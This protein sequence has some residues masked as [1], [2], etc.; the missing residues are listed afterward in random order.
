MATAKDFFKF[1]RERARAG[2]VIQLQSTADGKYVVYGLGRELRPLG[3]PMSTPA[4]ALAASLCW[5]YGADQPKHEAIKALSTTQTAKAFLQG[6]R[7]LGWEIR[8]TMADTWDISRTEKHITALGGG[9]A[10]PK[11]YFG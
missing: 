10:S 4:A 1:M 8:P 2:Q 7:D 6:V 9:F 11:N 3:K 5:L